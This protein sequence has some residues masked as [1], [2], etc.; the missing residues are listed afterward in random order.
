MNATKPT[1]EVKE[2]K[3]TL[4]LFVSQRERKARESLDVVQALACTSCTTSGVDER[5][6]SKNNKESF[7]A[8][9]SGLEA[10]SDATAKKKKKQKARRLA[11]R[12][13][14]LNKKHERDEIPAPL[15]VPSDIS[16][17]ASVRSRRLLPWA[18][19]RLGDR[20]LPELQVG[21]GD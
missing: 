7:V 19:D 6:R 8:L 18:R 12:R 17:R 10:W 16:Q 21:L 1:M 2:K 5:K 3:I 13:K 9:V 15:K 11:R 20:G 14:K 4:W